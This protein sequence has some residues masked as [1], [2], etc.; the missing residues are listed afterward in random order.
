M[1]YYN[2]ITMRVVYYT[3][4]AV[5]CERTTVIGIESVESLVFLQIP[6]CGLYDVP[7]S[8]CHIKVVRLRSGSSGI[9]MGVNI[10]GVGGC[11]SVKSWGSAEWGL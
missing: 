4:N 10:V 5:G 2:D 8:V 3:D 7:A 6:R 1:N 9:G 11:T